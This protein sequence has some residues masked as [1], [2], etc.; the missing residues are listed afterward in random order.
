MPGEVEQAPGA[1]R[2]AAVEVHAALSASRE[3]LTREWRI[4]GPMLPVRAYCPQQGIVK[5]LFG[6]ISIFRFSCK[7]E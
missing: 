4:L 5:S 7:P 2:F 1:A 3:P 6:R